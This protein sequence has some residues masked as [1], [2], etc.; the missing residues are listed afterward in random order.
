MN[1]HQG[2]IDSHTGLSNSFRRERELV[3]KRFEMIFAEI[4]KLQDIVEAQRKRIYRLEQR[5]T[6]LG[7]RRR[8]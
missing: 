4:R 2:L 6:R 7:D 1:S 5:V 3:D 8:G